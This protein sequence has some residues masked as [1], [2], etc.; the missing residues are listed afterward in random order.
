MEA[1][2]RLGRRFKL[3][4]LHT[5]FAVA[6]R[7]S[8]AKAAR[9]LALTQPAVTKAIADLESTV[10][11]R[12]FDRTP[13]GIELTPYGVALRKWGAAVFD[14]LE[15]AIKEIRF[16][17]DPTAG[18]LR[19]GCNDPL[20]GGLVPAVIDDLTKEYPS[21]VF[22]VT[23]FPQAAHMLR[24]L[25]ERTIDVGMGRLVAADEEDLHAEVLFEDPLVIAVGE[26][27]PWARRRS[28]KLADLVDEPWTM[29]PLNISPGSVI[30]EAFRSSGLQFPPR[31]VISRSVHLQVALVAAGRYVSV[32]PASFLRFVSKR[33]GIRVLPI[34][35]KLRPPP[36]GIV[37][38]RNR[39]PN[40]VTSLFIERVRAA[41]KTQK[42]GL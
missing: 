10:G 25:R 2:D 22:D 15:R 24:Q 42:M 26:G 33:T 17:A 3:R 28:I 13:Q 27:S 39:T 7:G 37:T 5:F 32:L 14:D 30:A 8:M 18:E 34:E 21:I 20:A 12:L 38:L 29:P 6:Q 23:Q 31:R 40:S 19:L 11:V 9:E 41:V 4:D 1:G 16:L 36:V 35:V